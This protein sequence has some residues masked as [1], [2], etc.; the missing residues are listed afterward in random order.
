MRHDGTDVRGTLPSV[1]AVIHRKAVSWHFG[2]AV[3]QAFPREAQIES[4]HEILSVLSISI[5]RHDRPRTKDSHLADAGRK[6][7]PTTGPTERLS[8]WVDCRTPRLEWWPRSH[9]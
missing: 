4:S 3:S 2:R 8:R 5:V 7:C 1:V 6:A 9:Q